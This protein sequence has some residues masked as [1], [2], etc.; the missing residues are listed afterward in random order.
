MTGI[1]MIAKEREEQL[2]KHKKTVEDDATFNT[3]YS[4]TNVAMSC[5]C[6]CWAYWPEGWSKELFEKILNKP[7]EE[8]LA[9]AGALIAA[10]IDRIQYVKEKTRK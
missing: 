4:M 3:V 8:R 9:I 6:K 7:T 5:L 2:N 10:E 1:E